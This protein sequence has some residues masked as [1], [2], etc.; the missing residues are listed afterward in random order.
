[1][2][3]KEKIPIQIFLFLIWSNERSECIKYSTNPTLN[4]SSS[5]TSGE[6]LSSGLDF[7]EDLG[8]DLEWGKDLGADLDW[9]EGLGS[10]LDWREGFGSGL[11]CGEGFKI[12]L[13]DGNITSWAGFE[14]GDNDKFE[15]TVW[16]FWGLILFSDSDIV[17][18]SSESKNTWNKF[19]WRLVFE[20]HY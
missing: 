15:G 18:S 12:G 5:S 13:G 19:V 8:S 14:V 2:P 7:G 11:D 20:Y 1:M 17:G 4:S 3:T 9:G 16:E 10:H 6:G